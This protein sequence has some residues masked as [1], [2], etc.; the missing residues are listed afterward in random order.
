MGSDETY[1]IDLYDRVLDCKARRQHCCDFLVGDPGKNGRRVRLPV[2]AYY[3]ELGC[4]IDVMERQHSAAVPFFDK[5]MTVSGITRGE[6]RKRYDARRREVLPVH[7]IRLIPLPTDQF[8]VR[9]GRL[10]REPKQ[11]EQIVRDYLQLMLPS[12]P[13]AR[14]HL[15]PA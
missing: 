11:H 1:L 7:G 8:P 4:V 2:D 15:E 6:R 3:A 12:Y 5:R 9:K 10:A 14:R 13:L